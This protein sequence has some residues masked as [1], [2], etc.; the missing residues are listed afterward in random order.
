[1]TCRCAIYSAVEAAEHEL[2][3]HNVIT[4]KKEAA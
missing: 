1:L 2:D 3:G 4:Y